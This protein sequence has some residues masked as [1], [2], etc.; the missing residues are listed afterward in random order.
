[1]HSI[2]VDAGL[3]D[4]NSLFVICV[5]IGFIVFLIVHIAVDVGC[6]F[7]VVMVGRDRLPMPSAA[8]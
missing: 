8:S 2:V 5:R 7:A 4:Q 6:E 1:M 3:A